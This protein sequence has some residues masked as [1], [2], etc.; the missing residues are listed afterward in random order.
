MKRIKRK[1]FKRQIDLIRYA[2]K[3]AIEHHDVDIPARMAFAIQSYQARNPEDFLQ[4]AKR[5]LKYEE[6]NQS[7]TI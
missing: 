3:R 2:I 5:R 7:T 1:V 6:T 4:Q